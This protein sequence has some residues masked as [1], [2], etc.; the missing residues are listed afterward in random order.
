MKN[1]TA[2]IPATIGSN[3]LLLTIHDGHWFATYRGPEAAR[4][5]RLFDTPTL[6]VPYQAVVPFETVAQSLAQTHPGFE[7]IQNS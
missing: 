7:I 2:V 1:E 4:I 6:P 3:S 5:V